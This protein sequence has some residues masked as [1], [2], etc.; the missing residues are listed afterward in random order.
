MPAPS[1][2]SACISCVL[3]FQWPLRTTARAFSN[4]YAAPG[5]G[6]PFLCLRGRGGRGLFFKNTHTFS[7]ALPAPAPCLCFCRHA[8]FACR[9]GDGV[10]RQASR[11]RTGCD[12]FTAAT[13]LAPARW[14]C[15][16]FSFSPNIAARCG[17]SHFWVRRDLSGI[18]PYPLWRSS[19]LGATGTARSGVRRFCLRLQHFILRHA[20][21]SRR[22]LTLLF[23]L[24]ILSSAGNAPSILC[25]TVAGGRCC[26]NG[27]M[28]RCVNSL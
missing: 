28:G 26:A 2:I 14:T 19:R 10:G 6:L 16:R 22:D 18:T 5:G 7:P 3:R 27:D 4:V 13:A 12:G 23:M 24:T 8:P 25:K 1:S 17:S 11:R 20:R 21:Y 9:T 15:S